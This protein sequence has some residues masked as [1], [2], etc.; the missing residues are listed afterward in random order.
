MQTCIVAQSVTFYEQSLVDA[1][2]VDINI[3]REDIVVASD[4][5]LGKR[6][7]QV[8][9]HS[10]KIK[11]E[12]LKT[13][14][15]KNKIELEKLYF[16]TQP[17]GNGMQKW[18]TLYSPKKTSKE[19]DMYSKGMIP[20]NEDDN[21]KLHFVQID[22]QEIEQYETIVYIE[23]KNEKKVKNETSEKVKK[24]NKENKKEEYVRIANSI[25]REAFHGNT[26]QFH[27]YKNEEG[28]VL[29]YRRTCES[30]CC[31]GKIHK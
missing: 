5:R 22:K 12:N 3:E 16:D 9:I 8:I 23:P 18:K 17:Y 11:R 31:W 10:K 24:N 14:I 13:Y 28:T 6:S 20:L 29:F 27:E 15:T 4:S 21:V 2:R 7:W 19:E 25:L 30:E 26:S 1:M